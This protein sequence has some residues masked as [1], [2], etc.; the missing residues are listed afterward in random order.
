[1]KLRHRIHDWRFRFRQA[2]HRAE[3]WIGR[4][5]DCHRNAHRL[6]AIEQALNARSL[7][8]N[9]DFLDEIADELDC[10]G[11]CDQITRE[12]DT[13]AAWCNR[14]E[15]GGY[16]PNDLAETLREIAKVGRERA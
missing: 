12:W 10:G 7:F 14:S 2:R 1:M 6:Q 15:K 3:R 5:R 4:V 16:C 9:P 8:A 11:M 13:G